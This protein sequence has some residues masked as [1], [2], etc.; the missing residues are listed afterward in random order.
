MPISGKKRARKSQEDASKK[1]AKHEDATAAA[2]SGAN[3]DSPKVNVAVATPSLV[4]S[5]AARKSSAAKRRRY[6]ESSASPKES[7]CFRKQ[8]GVSSNAKWYDCQ[9]GSNTCFE[10]ESNF[11]ALHPSL[12]GGHFNVVYCCVAWTA[13]VR[14]NGS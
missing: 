12:F 8:E 5:P 10:A 11:G 6:K 2:A 9:D 7:G 1:K 13:L 14:T 3:I 4:A